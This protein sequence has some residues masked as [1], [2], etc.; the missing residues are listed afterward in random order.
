M[1]DAPHE[2][3]SSDACPACRITAA[4]LLQQLPRSV[5]TE[6][7]S[8]TGRRDI[9]A[10]EV[11][12]TSGASAD[13]VYVLRAGRIKI[14]AG[15]RVVK[16]CRVGEI[17]GAGAVA[18]GAPHRVD[19]IALED[20]RVDTIELASLRIGESI[21]SAVR[22][23]ALAAHRQQRPE[24]IVLSVETIARLVRVLAGLGCFAGEETED[25]VRLPL[26]FSHQHV[27]ELLALP[28][29]AIT[30]IFEELEA[31]AVLYADASG[32]TILDSTRI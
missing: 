1:S 2:V 5:V 26:I 22:E 19:A 11:L 7:Q 31:R 32:V 29:N 17:L 8:S 15:R 24:A 16:I 20:C 14:C 9:A 12:Y 25:G 23:C 30:Q 28:E 21:R 10:G 27:G 3:E 18:A 4:E 6:L 13:A